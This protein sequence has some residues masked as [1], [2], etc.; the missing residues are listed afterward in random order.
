MAF[1]TMSLCHD[2]NGRLW[3]GTE[4]GVTYLDKEGF[5]NTGAAV[6]NPVNSIVEMDSEHIL[7]FGRD[8]LV[9][10]RKEGLAPVAVHSSVGTS[11]LKNIVVTSENDVWFAKTLNDSTFLYVLDNDLKEKDVKYLAKGLDVAGICEHPGGQI[12]VASD[13]GFL[14]FDMHTGKGERAGELDRLLGGRKIHFMLPYREYELLIGVAGEGF[15]AYNPQEEALRHIILQQTLSA[16]SYVCFV[17]KD[18]R[19]WLSDK[20]S[21]V[22]TYNPRGVYVHFNPQGEDQPGEV[23]HIFFDKEDYLWMILSGDLCSIDP[24]TGNVVWKN[25][26]GQSCRAMLIDS[27]GFMWAIFGQNDL[28]KF[29]LSGGRPSLVKSYEMKE[30]V[31]SLAEDCEGRIWISS[32][33]QL[34]V[35]DRSDRLKVVTH[36]ENLPFTFI[37]S[38]NCT[39]R[40][41]MFTVRD[42]L[43][44]IKGESDFVPV[45]TNGIK[46][47]NYVMCASDSTMWLGTYNDGLIGIDE[48]TG[49]V[50]AYGRESGLIDMSVR[51]ILEDHSGNIWFSTNSNIVKFD[52]E[53]GTFSTVHDDWF[54]EGRS[55]SLVSSASGKYDFLYFGGSAGIT[56]VDTSIPFPSVRDM[57]LNLERL[58]VNGQDMNPEVEELVLTHENSMI[59]LRFAG[60][61]Y[62]SG[63]YLGYSYMLEGYD[64]A[65]TY[66]YGDASAF[67]NHLPPGRYVFRARASYADGHWSD[68]ELSVPVI[69]RRKP[70]GILLVLGIVA[71]FAALVASMIMFWKK[72]QKEEVSVEYANDGVVED[73]EQCNSV[74]EMNAADKALLDKITE[75][76]DKNLDNDQYSVNDLAKDMSMSYS[77]MYAKVKA[78]TEKTPQR[79][80]TEYRMKKAEEFLKTGLFSVSEV[81]YKVGSSSPMT[82]SREFKKYFGYPPSTLLK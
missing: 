16:D 19:I 8:G 32:V 59:N 2:G 57:K 6:Y 62:D 1:Q 47:I 5:V 80:M 44:E 45:Q 4:C 18:D 48:K 68:N 10:F 15:Y 13:K 69:V 46:G 54:V 9:K 78:L 14:K 11:W 71:L 30:G 33:R 52:R 73:T 66:I 27:F 7:F 76:F 28:R 37:L 77:S 63:P 42:G 50:T 38:D 20:Q 25:E 22:R 39:R 34:Y 43:Y 81:S 29:S 3:I 35:L 12:Y 41:F 24:L 61:E 31:F 70:A 40:L 72:R 23:S 60:L 64:K 82:F 26:N 21:P 56:R 58:Q 75:L 51:S 53:T 17:D 79:F 55:Y 65:W 49:N 36:P 74:P 67:Y